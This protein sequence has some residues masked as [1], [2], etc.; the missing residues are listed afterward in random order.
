M[1]EMMKRNNQV[2]KIIQKLESIDKHDKYW[3]K[4]LTE[5]NPNTDYNFHLYHLINWI[6]YH[7]RPKQVLDIGVRSGGSL[8][9]LLDSYN[10]FKNN[11]KVYGFDIW[12]SYNPL[13]IP[14]FMDNYFT[15]L[16]QYLYLR[17]LKRNLRN[18][19]IPL[20]IFSFYAG[21]SKKT[22]P[23]FLDDNPDLF[24]DY[25]LVDGGK[26]KFTAYM[27]LMNTYVRLKKG[28]VLIFDDIH[29][30][31]CDLVTI[32]NVFKKKYKDDFHFYEYLSDKGNVGFGWCF[33]KC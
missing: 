4:F 15:G 10:F 8:I 3:K 5:L 25:I 18:M 14:H 19:C 11:V 16:R 21:D 12:D 26:D 31:N 7:H 22:I 1:N 30:H 28:G 33:K 2:Y 9:V 23:K 13:H 29:P 32:W 17:Y 20:D 27:D 24:F 6:G